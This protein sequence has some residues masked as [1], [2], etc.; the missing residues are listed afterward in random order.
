MRYSIATSRGKIWRV[1]DL[2]QLCVKPLV[3]TNRFKVIVYENPKCET[4]VSTRLEKPQFVTS[5]LKNS[6]RF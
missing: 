5:V 2:L 4:R 3:V 6:L 1:T